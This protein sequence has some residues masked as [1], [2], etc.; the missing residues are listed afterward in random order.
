M[1]VT[2]RIDGLRELGERLRKLSDEVA[3]KAAR[4]ATAA[5]AK[6]VKEQAKQNLRASPSV[7][8]GLVR[9]NVIIKKLGKRDSNLTSEHGVTVRKRAYPGGDSKRTTRKVASFLEFGTVKMDAEPFLQ[10]AL[11][12]RKEDAARA[13]ADRLKRAI[14]KAGG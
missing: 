6:L 10:P 9:D 5:G 3:N 14:D 1:S 11:D 12:K 13:I 7:E 2:I 8:S 4:S